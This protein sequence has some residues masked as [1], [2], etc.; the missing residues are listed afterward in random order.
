MLFL[1]R[2]IGFLLCSALFIGQAAAGASSAARSYR[3]EG[4]R[5]IES[6]RYS[7]AVVALE[8]AIELSPDYAEAWVDLGNA[9][10]ALGQH[11]EAAKAFDG[12]LSLNPELPVA[13]YNLAYALRRAG[14]LDKAIEA[15]RSY[16]QTNAEDADAHYGLAE[17][18]R[19]RGDKAAAAEA[20]DRYATTETRPDRKQWVDKAKQLAKELRE[21]EPKQAAAAPPP[22]TEHMSFSELK[23]E[24]HKRPKSFE[25]GLAKLK[26]GDFKGALAELEK[27]EAKAPSDPLILAALA[28]AQ[29]GSLESDRAVASY[30][31]ALVSAS[32]EMTPA[33]RFGLA[34]ALRAQKDE[35]G[36]LAAYRLIVND[37]NA[38]PEIKR[39]S[40]E[41]LTK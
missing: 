38:N 16:L 15:Y 31:R 6:K 36:S 7:D 25:S 24:D 34:E 41:R 17:T 2:A 21:I 13:R 22:T 1:A 18:L 11:A 20:Y 27:A 28:S 12:A 10:L 30:R 19:A 33:I 3:D 23:N 9:R 26:T 5:L 4:A 14:Q 39:L 35:E 37:P 29:L 8:K 40:K 32:P